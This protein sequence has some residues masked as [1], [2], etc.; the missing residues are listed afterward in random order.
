MNL[1][2]LGA[3]DRL[4]K[5][6]TNLLTSFKVID[7]VESE[8]VVK[9]IQDNVC[10]LNADKIMIHD[11]VLDIVSCDGTIPISYYFAHRYS[12]SELKKIFREIKEFCQKEKIVLIY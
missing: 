7:E 5:R 10:R 4:V 3:I 9:N 8:E 12:N 11:N 1:F 6:N 2:D